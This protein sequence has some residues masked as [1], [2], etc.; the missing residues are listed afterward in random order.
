MAYEEADG[1]LKAAVKERNELREKLKELEGW[2]T[3]ATMWS[4]HAWILG[5]QI[6][7]HIGIKK[8]ER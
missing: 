6:G 5:R 7:L 1:L 3:S 4:E 2:K 8:T